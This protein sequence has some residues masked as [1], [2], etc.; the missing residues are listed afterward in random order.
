MLSIRKL[1]IP[2]PWQDLVTFEVLWL[3]LDQLLWSVVGGSNLDPDTF[4]SGLGQTPG[5]DARSDETAGSMR[6]LNCQ[7]E[8]LPS[9]SRTLAMS[10]DSPGFLDD[11]N[12]INGVFALP[13]SHAL[14]L[15]LTP[16]TR[17]LNPVG[18]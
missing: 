1:K 13:E 3:Y 18:R 4:V 2:E 14:A 16:L 15:T 12:F 8:A 17:G 10:V 9:S 6:D 7:R 5:S 11:I